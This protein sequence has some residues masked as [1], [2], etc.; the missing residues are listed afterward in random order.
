MRY[1]ANQSP[2]SIAYVVVSMMV[3]A[4][5]TYSMQ[6]D[7]DDVRIR[8]KSQPSAV[9]AAADSFSSYSTPSHINFD[10][11]PDDMRF[12][13]FAD[14]WRQET[15]IMSSTTEMVMAP[16]YQHII[17]MGEKAVPFILRQ[18]EA[19]KDQPDNWFWALRSITG[20]NPVAPEL[21]GNRRG[22]AATWLEWG[23]TRYAW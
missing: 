12:G 11:I 9:V 13:Y 7:E 1:I 3:V 22:M 16:S 15:A 17:G 5:P 19:E 4:Q 21:R 20:H 2:Q 10:V 14:Q 23:R 18:L 8:V 6:C